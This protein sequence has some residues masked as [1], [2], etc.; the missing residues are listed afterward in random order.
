M[1][2]LGS[3]LDYIDGDHMEETEIEK[4][5]S[6]LKSASST[7]KLYNSED[8]LASNARVESRWATVM[9]SSSLSLD[10]QSRVEEQETYLGPGLSSDHRTQSY[11]GLAQL[12]Q[13]TSQVSKVGASP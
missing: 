9:K 10:R 8:I 12:Q 2:D 5:P 11:S 1:A 7:S 13:D 6:M 3:V 4:K